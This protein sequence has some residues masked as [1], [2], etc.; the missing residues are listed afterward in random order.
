VQEGFGTSRRPWKYA[1]FAAVAGAF[2]SIA[3]TISGPNDTSPPLILASGGLAA[4]IGYLIGTSWPEPYTNRSPARPGILGV[5]C[6]FLS[7][8]GVGILIGLLIAG[9]SETIWTCWMFALDDPGAGLKRDVPRTPF[10]LSI[11]LACGNAMVGSM[12]A[13][14]LGSL[15]GA[16]FG[17]S[18]RTDRFAPPTM[19]VA[20]WAG[21]LGLVI[22]ST[23]G[24]IAGFLLSFDIAWIVTLLAGCLAGIVAALIVWI[25]VKSSLTA[26]NP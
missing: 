23:A 26:V 5:I 15:A 7:R 8:L 18:V 13:A 9:L 24:A 2:P 20:L 4:V 25:L 22:G 21:L 10:S 1:L 3:A 17:A 12:L 16:F 14:F 19:L 6:R 11:G